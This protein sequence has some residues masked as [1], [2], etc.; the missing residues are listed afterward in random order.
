MTTKK[1]GKRARQN[2]ERVRGGRSRTLPAVGVGVVA[3][4]VEDRD[5]ASAEVVTVNR[6]TLD[7]TVPQGWRNVA[8]P[9][10]PGQRV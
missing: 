3:V 2:V 8:V 1:G 6:V 9:V 5:P 4:S 10:Q 7:S